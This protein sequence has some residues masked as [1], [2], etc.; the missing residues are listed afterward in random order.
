[1]FKRMFLILAFLLL[2]VSMA[3]AESSANAYDATFRTMQVDDVV[4]AT[5]YITKNHVV[6]LDVSATGVTNG[7][8]LGAYATET[9]TTDSVYTFGVADESFSTGTLGRVTVRGPHLVDMYTTGLTVL[10]KCISS[11][12]TSG[13]ASL[14]T[15]TSDGTEAGRL[16]VGLSNTYDTS[17][18]NA[19]WA[20]I[21]P[22]VHR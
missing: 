13:K 17:D 22:Y 18:T 6:I 10:G 3:R 21:N 1:M 8:T 4:Y 14:C 15:T 9:A 11:S 19:I 2:S 16:G 20:W 5:S 7:T 12:T